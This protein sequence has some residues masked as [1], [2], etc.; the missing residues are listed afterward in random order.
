[1]KTS[2][3]EIISFSVVAV[4][5]LVIA[6]FVDLPLSMNVYNETN[7]FGRIFAAFGETPGILVGVFSCAALIAT[8]NKQ[9][10]WK[11]VL[12]IIGFGLLMLLFSVMAGIMPMNYISIPLAV[13]VI[14]AV[15]YGGLAVL[16]AQKL[17][18][19][20]PKALRR[21][22]TVGLI[23]LFLAMVVINIIKIFWG[24]PRIRIMDDPLTQFTPWYLPQGLAAS[25]QYKSFPSGHSANAAVII[26]ISLLPAFWEAARG[27]AKAI[28]LRVIAYGWTVMV[29]VS[30]IIM[31]AHFMSDVVMGASLT[32]LMFFMLTNIFYKDTG[33]RIQQS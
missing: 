6:S 12:S 2:K 30:R 20:N 1:M 32:I 21:A 26:W 11:S 3:K 22:A 14:M 17:A 23:L 25:D 8:R 10:K 7:L 16:A 15:A 28:L 9:V 29:M 4:I 18:K 33:K 13:C 19:K 5:L 31:G 27:K 24:R